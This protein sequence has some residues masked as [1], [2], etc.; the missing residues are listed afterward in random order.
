MP[1]RELSQVLDFINLMA[2]DYTGSWEKTSGHAQNLYKSNSNPDSTPYNTHD[3]VQAYFNAG[4][5]PSKI[6]LGMP[7]YGRA[8][9]NTAGLGKPFNGNGKGSWEAGV[10]DFKDLPLPG[11]QV[12]YDQE[13]GATY[14]YDKGTGMLVSYDTV[15]MALKKTD[16]LKKTGL[17]GA[18]WWEVSGD[19]YDGTGL[20]DN[21]VASLRGSDGN[22]IQQRS[23]WLRY[24]DSEFDN[25]KAMGP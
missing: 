3:V 12:F 17:G 9:T 25:I 7:L 5:T 18:M 11:A 21:V 22:G 23:N 20:I 24:P 16:W 13:A 15:D 10:Y 4:V 1:L 2:Y 19:R 14:S 8:F 6:N